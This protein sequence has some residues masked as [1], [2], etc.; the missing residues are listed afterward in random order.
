MTFWPVDRD[1]R[2]RL[3]GRRPSPFST[4]SCVTSLLLVALERERAAAVLVADELHVGGF[5]PG[6]ASASVVWIVADRVLDDLGLHPDALAALRPTSVETLA[7]AKP[8]GS[9]RSRTS[10]TCCA[11]LPSAIVTCHDVPPSKSMPRLSPRDEQRTEAD[12]DERAREDQPPAR[13]LDEL[14]VRA[15]VVEVRRTGGGG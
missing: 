5:E 7:S 10:L 13:V 6:R 9:R 11:F 2:V 4:C 12:Q 15:L 14:E 1:R 8:S 3:T